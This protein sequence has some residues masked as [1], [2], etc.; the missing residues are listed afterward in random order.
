MGSRLSLTFGPCISLLL[1]NDSNSASNKKRFLF[2]SLIEKFRGRSASG[3]AGS[4]GSKRDAGRQKNRPSLQ[5]KVPYVSEDEDNS[6]N[7]FC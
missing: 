6:K 4:R 1:A 5:R 3:V 7:I 2:A